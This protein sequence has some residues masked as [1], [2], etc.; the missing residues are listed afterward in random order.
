MRAGGPSLQINSWQPLLN[1]SLAKR[2][3]RSSTTRKENI[4]ICSFLNITIIN[5]IVNKIISF[6]INDLTLLKSSRYLK[7]NKTKDV[8]KYVNSSNYNYASDNEVRRK[9]D[10]QNYKD[11]INGRQTLELIDKVVQI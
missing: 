7:T 3:F 10:A 2:L 8:H 1:I 4:S 9:N 11:K 6:L 5:Y